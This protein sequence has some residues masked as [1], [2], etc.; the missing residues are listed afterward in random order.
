MHT[1]ASRE[2]AMSAHTATVRWQRNDA[3]FAGGRYSRRHE[4]RFDGGA[5]VAASPSPQVV[6]PPWSDAS[7]IDPEE[8]FVAAI[9][10]C[11]MLWF[12]SLAAERGFVVDRYEDDAVGT[13]A[14]IAPQRQ[15]IAEV[16]LRP[17]VEFATGH[18][19]DAN[20]LAALH[21]AAHERCF[22]AN[23]VTTAIRV[24]TP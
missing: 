19:A 21:E 18:A 13:M 6:A 5:V 16:V 4:W 7:A 14:R 9:S 15:A 12:L 2:Q 20:A 3:D 8:A 23:S 22:I 11:H 17:R 10:S 1:P 24:E